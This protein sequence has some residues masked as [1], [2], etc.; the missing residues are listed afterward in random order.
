VRVVCSVDVYAD[1]MSRADVGRSQPVQNEGHARRIDSFCPTVTD[2]HPS[3]RSRRGAQSPTRHRLSL[4]DT[5]SNIALGG[6]RKSRTENDALENGRNNAKK[7]ISR[8]RFCRKA[9]S[10]KI[11]QSNVNLY[12]AR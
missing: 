12:S 6:R 5:V 9:E 8:R 7:I 2:R 3:H 1:E 10:C 4:Y 11:S